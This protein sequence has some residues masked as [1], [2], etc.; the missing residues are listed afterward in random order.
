[1]KTQVFQGGIGRPDM[2]TASTFLAL[3]QSENHP[4]RLCN[5]TGTP[6]R[7]RWWHGES[8]IEV[9][10]WSAEDNEVRVGDEK[11]EG[12]EPH[13]VDMKYRN[14]EIN[15]KT[16]RLEDVKSSKWK[17]NVSGRRIVSWNSRLRTK[18]TEPFIKSKNHCMETNDYGR[19]TWPE[20][21]KLNHKDYEDCTGVYFLT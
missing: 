20:G 4:D 2:L 17:E 8:N 12:M 15:P 9:W 16:L 14:L 3:S 5:W 1:M 10:R 7:K 21:D 18:M 11:G 6:R 19:C 13:M